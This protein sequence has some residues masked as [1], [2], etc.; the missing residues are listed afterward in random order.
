MNA[1]L[2]IVILA[3]GLGKRMHSAL[4]K[5]LHPL[6]GRPLLEHVIDA[7]R[8]LRPARVCVVYGHGGERVRETV[9][10]ADVAWVK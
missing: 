3:A 7:A 4:P 10:D 8:A 2:Q 9:G 5:V 1:G 6:A